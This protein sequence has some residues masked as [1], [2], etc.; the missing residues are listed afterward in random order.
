M[1]V[2]VILAAES[3]HTLPCYVA[4]VFVKRAW[5]L[6]PYYNVSLTVFFV[7]VKLPFLPHLKAAGIN[8]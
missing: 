1:K 3:V 7:V 8:S 6:L 2:P 5:G 4:V